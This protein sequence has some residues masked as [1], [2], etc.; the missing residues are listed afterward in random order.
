MA[1]W[2]ASLASTP[3]PQGSASEQS[4]RPQ[5]TPQIEVVANPSLAGNS[6]FAGGKNQALE[7]AGAVADLTT[8]GQEFARTYANQAQAVA[9]ENAK[10]KAI[11]NKGLGFAEAVRQG[12]IDPTASPGG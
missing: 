5:N 1:P 9:R 8:T 10:Q 4:S 3:S 7:L 12:K 11:T 6:A 2:V